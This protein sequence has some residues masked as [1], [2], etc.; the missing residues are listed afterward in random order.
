MLFKKDKA[1]S[2]TYYY[3][4]FQNL[5]DDEPI[6]FSILNNFLRK[7]GQNDA[8]IFFKVNSSKRYNTD[9]KLIGE[10]KHSRF[11][12]NNNLIFNEDIFDC[13]W[14]TVY[15]MTN[16][17]LEDDFIESMSCSIK[18]A[19]RLRAKHAK[20]FICYISFD[21]I[22]ECKMEVKENF[23]DELIKLAEGYGDSQKNVS[24]KYYK[25]F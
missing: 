11:F 10:N 3:E 4:L 8:N 7:I 16:D 24:T 12:K 15:V 9:F 13:K 25:K 17:Y 14:G 5:K 19:K 2:T 23:K 22:Y 6:D 18:D 1:Y 21:D 20:K